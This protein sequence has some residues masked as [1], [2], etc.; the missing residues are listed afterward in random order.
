MSAAGGVITRRARAGLVFTIVTAL[1][2]FF[3]LPAVSA[4]RTTLSVLVPIVATESSSELLTVDELTAPTGL[5]GAWR[6]L[7]DVA[8]RH[9]AT[10]ALDS[11]II[12]S[13]EALGDEVPASVST[14]L[15][16]VL[17]VRPLILPWG[18]ADPFVLAAVGQTHRV[19]AIALGEIAGVP[20]ADIVGWPTGRAG[21]D[22]SVAR[23]ERLGYTS[24][25]VDDAAFPD[26]PGALSAKLSG[27]IRDAVIPGSTADIVDAASA[28][29]A[30]ANTKTPVTLPRN[31]HDIDVPR[32]VAFLDA[33]FAGSTNSRRFVPSPVGE[34][35]TFVFSD[36]P[37]RSI[38]LLMA[39]HRTDRR[40]STMAADPSIISIPRL[41]RL[42]VLAGQVGTANFAG[43]VRVYVRDA[44][45]YEEF[46]S[47]T[48]GADFTVL[49]NSTELPLTVTNSSAS[50]ITV[51]ATVNAVSGIVTIS[52]PAQEVTVPAGS[53][54]QVLFPMASVANGSTSLRATLTTTDGIPISEPVSVAIDVQA[55]WEGLTLFAFV[56]L[57]SAIMGVG[58]VRTIRDRRARS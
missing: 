20:T 31:A 47:F 13:I 25:I 15:D 56:A 38:R 41:R 12:A 9:G 32:A 24:L 22:R 21:S 27:T 28:V 40:V 51:V 53:S 33:L 49:A 29:R 16:S 48:L 57:V 44:A 4:P 14:W 23:I 46:I 1:L 17:R 45:S 26:A 55:Q 35:G 30:L 50:D 19:S 11:R 42:C 34:V 10:I 39:Q 7:S 18:N 8:L 2:G 52:K 58:I 6:E 43:L 37:D 54:T 36:I 5:G 3:A